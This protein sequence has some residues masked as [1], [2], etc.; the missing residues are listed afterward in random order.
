MYQKW[1]LFSVGRDHVA[2]PSLARKSSVPNLSRVSQKLADFMAEQTAI[3]RRAANLAMPHIEHTNKY[4]SDIQSTTQ[5]AMALCT[6]EVPEKA[7]ELSGGRWS[8]LIKVSRPHARRAYQDGRLPD[9]ASG[10]LRARGDF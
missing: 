3:A 7:S 5:H 4:T 9:W 1:W 10:Y 8:S 6:G 2:S